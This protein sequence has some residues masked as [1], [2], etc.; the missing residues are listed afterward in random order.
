MDII[1]GPKY[2]FYLILT[3]Y[4]VVLAQI[5]YENDHEKLL[6]GYE[7]VGGTTALLETRSY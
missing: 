7:Q 2:D 5:S 3:Q 6:A 4:E 1:R